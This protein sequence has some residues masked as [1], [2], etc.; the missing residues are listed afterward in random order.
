MLENA[1]FGYLRT[2]G[3]SRVYFQDEIRPPAWPS[4]FPTF[5]GTIGSAE[6]CRERMSPAHSVLVKWKRR[7]P[8]PSVLLLAAM[9]ISS[10]TN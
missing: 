3:L 1:C 4:P 2:A 9:A 10:R 7:M 5:A 8:P 6:K